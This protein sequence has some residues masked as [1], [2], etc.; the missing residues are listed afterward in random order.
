MVF[1]VLG[2]FDVV[3]VWVVYCIFACVLRLVFVVCGLF[4]AVGW[5][6]GLGRF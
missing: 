6:V 4:C 1:A 3:K 5:C 2:W